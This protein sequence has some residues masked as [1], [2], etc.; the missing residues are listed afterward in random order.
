MGARMTK[1]IAIVGAGVGG[2][3]TAARLAHLGHEVEVFEKL[4]ECGGRAHIIEDRGFK[5]DTGPSFVL[6]PDFFEELFS[7]CG[8]K[9]G[10]FLE[11][12]ALETHYKIFYGD[13]ST[14][15]VFRDADRT[16]E[17]LER[18]EPGS[19]KAYDDF[20]RD[21]AAVYRD[22]RPLLYKCFTK[23]SVA[24]PRYWRLLLTLKPQQS[25]W[26][27][28]RKFFTSDKLGYAFTFQA[29][30]IG[31]SP[32]DS[33]GFYSIITYADHVQK[34]F[35]PTGGMYQI[36]LA[37]EKLAREFG[38]RFNYNTPVEAIAPDNGSIGIVTAGGTI[39]A[40]A[41]VV[42]ADY[43]YAQHTLLRRKLPEYRYSCSVYLIY[44]GLKQKLQGLEHHTLFLAG[45]VRKNLQRIC[46][47]KQ[48]ADDL[49]FY[50]HIPTAT[51]QSLAPAGKEIVYI[52][53]PVANL[54]DD[55]ESFEGAEERIRNAVFSRV[56]R[57]TGIDLP[58]LV[59][60]EHRF[61]PRD[62]IT[63][64]N[65]QY[66]ATFGL[67]HTLLQSAFFRP[68]NA[69]AAVKNIFYVGASTQPGG[70]LPPVIASSKIV[71]DLI[72]T[73]Q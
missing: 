19:T 37:F 43:A 10:D 65:V 73:K 44:L 17:E 72:D 22:V 54:Q 5:F 57:D 23:M 56:L 28:V 46:D 50:I 18:I 20:I 45:D 1:K 34:I 21:T 40:D 41:V 38:A 2:L 51:D 62:F 58:A 8:K 32:F 4:P 13:G 7:S 24:N 48:L 30:F 12:Q 53:V 16:R 68:P 14:F 27:K 60:V 66:G 69:D 33:P 63:R 15:T 42:N 29:M 6:M 70:G 55:Q 25:Y 26:Q 61:Y 39:D 3:A 9:I 35:H 47:R 11:L 52:L 71:A 67:S 31:V 59:E 36:P 49:S 64:Y